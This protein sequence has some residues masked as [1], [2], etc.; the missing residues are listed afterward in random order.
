MKQVNKLW[1]STSN[2]V[3]NKIFGGNELIEH[4]DQFGNDLTRHID[5]EMDDSNWELELDD[6]K[7][8][9]SK[10]IHDLIK[11]LDKDSKNKDTTDDAKRQQEWDKSVQD[12]ERGMSGY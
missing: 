6:D 4:Q 7:D 5:S 1:T 10:Q 8:E 12:F 3:T 2:L 11:Q 9:W